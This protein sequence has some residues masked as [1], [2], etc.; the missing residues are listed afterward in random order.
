MKQYLF[1]IK[2]PTFACR[3]LVNAG[4]SVP[5]SVIESAV[6]QAIQ[7]QQVDLCQHAVAAKPTAPVP[8]VSSWGL[9]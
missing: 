3:V 2:G 5:V 1:Q 7:E 4:E 9:N 8:A 6:L